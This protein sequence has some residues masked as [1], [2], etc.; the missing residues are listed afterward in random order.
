MEGKEEHEGEQTKDKEFRVLYFDGASKTNSIG[1][2]LFLQSLDGFLTEY[3][4]KLDFPTINNE[5]KYEA[6]IAG[7]GLAGTLKVK[8]LKVCGD[9]KLVIS[10]VKGELKVRDETMEKYVHLGMDILGP[11]HMATTQS[12]FLIVAID[13]FNKWIEAKPLAKIIAKKV[14]QFLWE[15]IMCRYGIPHILVTDN[16]TQFNNEEFRKHCEENEI[17]LQLTSVAHPQAN[18]QAQMANRIILDGLKKRI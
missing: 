16:E 15:N 13:Y 1:A 2:G 14:A 8:N 7:L 6:L 18:G 3:A 4:M 9:S 12:K 5:A 11:F 17:E 10:R